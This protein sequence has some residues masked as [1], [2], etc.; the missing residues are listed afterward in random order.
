MIILKIW[1]LEQ[2]CK[3]WNE[4]LDSYKQQD[5]SADFD[6]FFTAFVIYNR[7]YNVV[8]VVLNE[9]GGFTELKKLGLIEKNRNIVLEKNAATICVAYYLQ[10]HTEEL[11]NKLDKE[12]NTFK[13]AIEKKQFYFYLYYGKRKRTKDLEL[14][15]GLNSLNETEKLSSLLCIIYH[16]RC[17]LF[18]GEKG[19]N[20]DQSII[21]RP[22]II[23]LTEISRILL[24]KLR[25]HENL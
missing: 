19:Y 14:L 17:N 7:I 11:L 22:A 18:H 24:V 23:C 10:Q 5:L 12:I 9:T 4:K 15:Q 8:E 2:F 16:L 1:E 20:P 3:R 13:N 25:N 6:K 21:L